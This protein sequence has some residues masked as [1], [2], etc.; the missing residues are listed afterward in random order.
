MST[1]RYIMIESNSGYVWGAGDAADVISACRAMD[2]MSGNVG[3]T[4]EEH[5]PRSQ[6]ARSTQGGYFVYEAPAGFD[7]GDGRDESAVAQVM[8]L[9]LVAFVLTG[10]AED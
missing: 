9:P 3:R 8:A 1:T 10:D 6:A 7:V 5:G 2:E 4:Y